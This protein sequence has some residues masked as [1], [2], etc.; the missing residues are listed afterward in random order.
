VYHYSCL[1]YFVF[2]KGGVGTF[3]GVCAV[4]LGAE[5][6]EI[7]VSLCSCDFEFLI[8]E[9]DVYEFEKREWRW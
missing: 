5:G 3:D 6:C 1:F 9:A 7:V 2:Y 4:E 8:R